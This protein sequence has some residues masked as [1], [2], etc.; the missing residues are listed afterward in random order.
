MI[1]RDLNHVH[2]VGSSG[3]L[4]EET[5]STFIP[6]MANVF[7]PTHEEVA[8]VNQIYEKYDLHEFDVITGGV[9]AAIFSGAN[10]SPCTSSQIWGIADAD[11]QGFLTR[12]GVSVAMRLIGCARQGE[13]IS[14]ELVNKRERDKSTRPNL[15]TQPGKAGPLP[16]IDGV[17]SAECSRATGPSPKSLGTSRLSSPLTAQDKAKF[18]QYYFSKCNP[19]NGVLSGVHGHVL[20]HHNRVSDLN[21][22]PKVRKH[23]MY[24]SSPS[25]Q[26]SNSLRYGVSHFHFLRHF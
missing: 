19:V 12:K 16:V 2:G 9:A 5:P 24:L 17:S 21:L 1:T 7:S 22:F 14:A 26:S 25:S 20:S 18:A 23:A 13:V 11:N 3:R 8:L 6:P 4:C 15:I 10:L